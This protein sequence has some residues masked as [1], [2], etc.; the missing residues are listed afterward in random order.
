MSLK[1]NLSEIPFASLCYQLRQSNFSGQLLLSQEDGSQLFFFLN[2]DIILTSDELRQ[3]DFPYFLSSEKILP[4]EESRE[5]NLL[6]NQENHLPIEILIEKFSISPEKIWTILTNFIQFKLIPCFDWSEGNFTLSPG[7]VPKTPEILLNFSLLKLIRQGILS[8]QNM[9]LIR[10]SLP[11]EEETLEISSPEIL[12][13]YP[14]EMHERYVIRL[15]QTHK[16]LSQLQSASQL[17]INET[18]RVLYLL[19]NTGLVKNPKKK[20]LHLK[21]TSTSHVDV[22]NILWSFNEKF[23]YIF[24]YLSKEVGPVASNIVE[25]S[26]QE[27]KPNLPPFF[28][29]LNLTPEGKIELNRH[30][31]GNI[32]FI[33]DEHMPHLIEGL[34][35]I[36]VSLLFAVKRALGN[37]HESALVKNLLSV[38]KWS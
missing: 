18:Q 25:K 12:K 37:E 31:K 32:G 21:V 9:N 30:L 34:N 3:P 13:K 11:G 19:I 23:T 6:L 5:L 29:S 7:Q 16:T 33:N 24:K 1:G 4:L 35:E 2:G 27:T 15:I 10:Q 8:M 22:A 14:Q 28:S 20:S 38:G 17:G 36:L 26:I